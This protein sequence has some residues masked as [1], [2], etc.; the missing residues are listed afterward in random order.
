MLRDLSSRHSS[1][2]STHSLQAFTICKLATLALAG[3]ITAAPRPATEN[4]LSIL[5][6]WHV[7]SPYT[8]ELYLSRDSLSPAYSSLLCIQSLTVAPSIEQPSS[9]LTSAVSQ[10]RQIQSCLLAS[11]ATTLDTQEG[12]LAKKASVAMEHIV[13]VPE[14]LALRMLHMNAWYIQISA[15]HNCYSICRM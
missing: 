10:T 8:C 11:P 5:S 2:H 7:G 14:G 13:H 3:L 15:R 9:P 12:I 6:A 4:T 1:P